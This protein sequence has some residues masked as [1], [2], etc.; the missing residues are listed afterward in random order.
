MRETGQNVITIETRVERLWCEFTEAK[1]R[2]MQPGA[3]VDDG[4]AAGRA[5]S[6]F[7]SEFVGHDPV[8]QAVHERSRG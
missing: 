2:A 7:L 4:I 1:R 3:T 6:S 8:K 5:W